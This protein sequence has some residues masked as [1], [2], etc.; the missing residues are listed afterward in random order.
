MKNNFRIWP[1]IK[2]VWPPLVYSIGPWPSCTRILHRL[3]I[4]LRVGSSLA[5]KRNGT[6]FKL[7]ISQIVL[8]IF[9]FL[10]RQ[11]KKKLNV[12]VRSVFY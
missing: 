1:E 4:I 12:G 9:L 11:V 3:N 2:K 6:F 8:I 7:Y 10:T 5:M